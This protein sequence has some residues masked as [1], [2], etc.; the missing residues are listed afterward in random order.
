MQSA[1]KTFLLRWLVNFFG[2]WTAATLLTNSIEYG[3]RVRVLIIAALIFSIVNALVRPLVIILS[4]PAIVLSLGLFIFVINA[5]M[6]YIVTLIY[7][8]FS[9]E[10]VGSA[11]I[12]VIIIWIVNFLLSDLLEPKRT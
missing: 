2:L 8:S 9:V 3:D 12:A 1:L 6:L 5:F 4:L 11:L 7:P 10:S